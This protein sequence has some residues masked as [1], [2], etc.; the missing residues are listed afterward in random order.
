MVEGLKTGKMERI[1]GFHGTSEAAASEILK[2]SFRKSAGD[3]EW[4]GDGVY[5]FTEG[6]SDSPYNQVAE[7]DISS[8]YYM[9]ARGLRYDKYY[10]LETRIEVDEEH[11]LDLTVAEGIELLNYFAGRF[12]EKISQTGK[13]LR[14]ADG[15]L[16][17]MIRK[18][19]N[20]SIDVAKGNFYI[21]FKKER[22]FKINLRTANCTILS[23]YDPEKCCKFT[24]VKKRGIVV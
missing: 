11:F 9:L 6:R 8:A 4:L 2:T 14:Y 15:L 20:L 7:W 13:R 12:R 19:G 3:A 17:N 16:I 23:V 1:V 10:V 24:S 5:F 22:I 18:H 21:K